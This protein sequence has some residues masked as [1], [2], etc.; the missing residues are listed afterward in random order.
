MI[1]LSKVPK[2]KISASS[3]AGY[4]LIELIVVVL[5][6]GAVFAV[7]TVSGNSLQYWRQEAAIRNISELVSFLHRRA[8]SDGVTYQLSFDLSE[9]T[10]Q[11]S[12]RE[13]VPEQAVFT[14]QSTVS[15]SNTDLGPLA[16]ELNSLLYPPVF[17]AANLIEPNSIPSLAKPVPL[18]RGMRFVDIRTTRG[19][20]TENGLDGTLPYIR[21]SPRGFSDFAVIHLRTETEADTT[22]LVNPFTG[23]T[24][25]YREYKE[26]EWSYGKR[27][28]S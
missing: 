12:V 11:Y 4:T 20:E 27:N 7:F 18:P 14:Q 16:L 8:V 24:S 23:I 22:I 13:V 25:I 19:K 17:T 9:E 5:I 26:F 6:I 2:G 1:S 10:P 21:F 3:I 15:S 28:N